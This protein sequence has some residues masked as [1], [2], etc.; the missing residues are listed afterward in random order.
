MSGPVEFLR[1]YTE[2]F[3]QLLA[4]DITTPFTWQTSGLY[5]SGQT[6]IFIA[7]VPTSPDRVVTI[8]PI[9]LDASP[10]LTDSRVD[11][12]IRFRAGP[13]IR[14]VWSMRDASR[15]V[16]AARFPLRLPGGIY[17]SRLELAYG[18]S[19]GQDDSHRWEWSDSYKTR[20]SE[21]VTARP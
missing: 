13:D 1:L 19:L 15:R 20:A 14:D 21:P 2:G 5:S 11:L 6:G 17:I 4:D 10:T 12:Q 9:P 3:A 16:L 18:G 7:A 8:T